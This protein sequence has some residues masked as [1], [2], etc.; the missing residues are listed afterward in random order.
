MKELPLHILKLSFIQHV[1]EVHLKRSLTSALT[2]FST[3]THTQKKTV[4]RLLDNS[5]KCLFLKLL[6]NS[7]QEK[8]QMREEKRCNKFKE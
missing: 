5:V 8:I 2:N 4:S 3:H 6:V 7:I 1:D